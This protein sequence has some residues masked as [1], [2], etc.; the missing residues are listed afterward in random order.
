[1]EI[2]ASVKTGTPTCGGPTFP[3]SISLVRIDGSR[4]LLVY[5]NRK[6]DGDWSCR[7]GKLS[8]DDCGWGELI[9]LSILEDLVPGRPAL[10]ALVD[11]FVVSG[12][13]RLD[14]YEQHRGIASIA[15]RMNDLVRI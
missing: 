1:M 2:L 13:F 6:R 11:V 4:H 9:S 8:I 3:I 14:L 5:R 15:R 12:R 10:R 7:P